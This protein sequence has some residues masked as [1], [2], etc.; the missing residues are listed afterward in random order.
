MLDSAAISGA[1]RAL[2]RFAPPFSTGPRI[3]NGWL[4]PSRPSRDVTIVICTYERP[5]HLRRGLVSLALQ[6]RLTEGFEVVVTDDGS[7]DGTADMVADF[8][9]TVDFPIAFTS[10]PHEGY[11]VSR[12]RN[13]GARLARGS[14]LLFL[15]GDCI[16]PHDHL[17]QHLAFRRRG[18]VALGDCCRLDEATSA[19]VTDDVLASGE[20]QQWATPAERRRLWERHAKSWFYALIGHRRKPNLIGNNVGV[21]REDFVRVNGYDENYREWGC[22]DDD[23]GLRLRWGGCRMRSILGRTWTYHLWH[24]PHSSVPQQ[25]HDGANAQ[26]FLS[27]PQTPWCANGLVKEPAVAGRAA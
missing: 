25:W 21:W 18:V 14:Y 11:Q 24:P 15:D 22:E 26:Y 17:A 4:H 9:R 2:P 3:M 8:A 13:D 27:R 23:F 20:Y 16:V 19:R 7:Q 6:R 1:R 5:E 10:H 12:T